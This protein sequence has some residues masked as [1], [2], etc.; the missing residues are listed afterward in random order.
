MPIRAFTDRGD[1][2][3][4]RVMDHQRQLAG[5]EDHAG[6]PWSSG[7]DP[8]QDAPIAERVWLTRMV[9]EVTVAWY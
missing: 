2:V 6:H 7:G 1:A 9:N 8:G 4:N 3:F 5:V